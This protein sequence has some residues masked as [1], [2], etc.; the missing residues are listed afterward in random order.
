MRELYIT[1]EG[2]E[3]YEVSNKGNVRNKTTKYILKPWIDNKGYYM[4]SIYEKCK[5]KN[6]FVH[7]LISEA[8]IPNPENKP[9]VDH[10]DN[11]TLNNKIGNL[12]WCTYRENIWNTN[13]RKTNTSG[14]KGVSFCKTK[15]IWRARMMI[16]G[17]DI[18]LGCFIDKKDA[19]KARQ[20]A[21][22]KMFGEFTNQCEK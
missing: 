21:S 7:R 3:N 11:N 17:Q 12:R 9:C 14:I 19:I 13:I 22:K 1:I 5:R 4:V 8:F 6:K 15:K 16:K 10:I 20:E 2:F 18:Y